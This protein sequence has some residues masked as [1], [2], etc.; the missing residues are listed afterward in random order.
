M[1][2]PSIPAGL[3]F[4]HPCRDCGHRPRLVG[5]HAVVLD[6]VSRGWDSV[7]VDRA[8]GWRW[9]AA[10]LYT[11][12]AARCLHT[13]ST[14]HAID[15]AVRAGLL[16]LPG[17]PADDRLLVT[18]VM[19]TTGQLIADGHTRQEIAVIRGVGIKAVSTSAGRLRESLH[20]G[21]DA[22]VVLA[23]HALGLLNTRHPCPCRP[24]TDTA[25]ESAPRCGYASPA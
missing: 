3:V 18:D 8:Y 25:A 10:A 2:A 19:R 6:L 14:V 21:T 20:V 17:R 22:E 1:T 15:V 24:Q 12:V 7:E 11:R 23:L 5:G 9:G 13:G 16:R 4:G